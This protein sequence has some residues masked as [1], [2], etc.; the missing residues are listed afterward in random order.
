LLTIDFVPFV[1]YIPYGHEE[2]HV[3]FLFIVVV[4]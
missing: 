4:V 3:F 1:L 2:I